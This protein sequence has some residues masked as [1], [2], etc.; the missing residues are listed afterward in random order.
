MKRRFAIAGA[1]VRGLCF[2]RALV[3]GEYGDEASLVALYDLN[4]SRMKGFN[5]IL[6]ADIPIYT[7][8]SELADKSA[9]THLIICTPDAIH[10]Q[11]IEQA[12]RHGMEAVTEKPMTTDAEKVRHILELEKKYGRQVTVTFNYRFV[13]YVARIKEYLQQ[14]K[15]G[16][17]L[18]V[19]LEWYLDKVH[20][21]EYFRRWHSD[22]K[23]SGGLL[24]HKATHHFDLI[25]WLLGDVPQEVSAFGAL[26]VYG[27]NG[28][29]RGERCSTCPHAGSKCQYEMKVHKVEED[30]EIFDKIYW[31]AENEDGYIR[32][33]CLFDPDI[34]IYDT[35]SVLVKYRGG[36]QLSYALNAYSPTEGYR[37]TMTGTEGRLEASETHSGIFMYPKEEKNSFKVYTGISRKE[38]HEEIIEVD[39]DK[40]DHG[41]GDSRLYRHLFTDYAD[42]PLGQMAGSYDGAMSCL[43][44]IGANLSIERGVAVS[45]SGLLRQDK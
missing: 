28:T 12:L 25:N 43:T 5:G 31:E 45:I 9:P 11:F 35:M 36:A 37:L 20:G 17:I 13:P 3:S 2:A 23:M 34:D 14:E 7:D 26:K 1:G 33:R 40:S 22:M 30:R 16:K 18:S 39:S 21:A 4:V 15:L 19:T 10:H 24:V 27:R 6:K 32:D 29:F 42:D 8:F 41:G 44:G 38:L